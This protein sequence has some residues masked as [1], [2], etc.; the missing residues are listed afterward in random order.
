MILL[1]GPRRSSDD[2]PI[3]GPTLLCRTLLAYCMTGIHCFYIDTGSL[4]FFMSIWPT[5]MSSAI[6]AGGHRSMMLYSAFALSRS[7]YFVCDMLKDDVTG[8]YILLR[9]AMARLCRAQSAYVVTRLRAPGGVAYTP[10]ALFNLFYVIFAV[11]Y[12]KQALLIRLP[13]VYYAYGEIF[14]MSDIWRQCPVP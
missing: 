6:N 7:A 1:A 8:R 11:I 5:A 14:Y 2:W 3:A 12:L 10:S 13:F 4:R 9:V